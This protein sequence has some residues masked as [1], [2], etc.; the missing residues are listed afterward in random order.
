MDTHPSRR[1]DMALVG[2]GEVIAEL[3]AHDRSSE[4]ITA[5]H[6]IPARE[7]QWAP[8]PDWIRPELVEAYRT[9][10]VVQLYSHQAEA[11]DRIRRGSAHRENDDCPSHSRKTD[12]SPHAVRPMAMCRV[13]TTCKSTRPARRAG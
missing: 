9:K 3:T 12:R 6:Q 7:A 4:V 8:M 2:V 5:V 10:G 11:V 13:P 1:N